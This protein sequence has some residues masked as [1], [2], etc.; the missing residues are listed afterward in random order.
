MADRNTCRRLGE[1]ARKSVFLVAIPVVQ[2]VCPP[3][4]ASERENCKL[5]KVST[6]I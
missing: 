5:E 2:N 4:G 1:L 6:G 3:S